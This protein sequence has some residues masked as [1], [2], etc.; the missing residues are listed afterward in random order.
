MLVQF[1]H[2]PRDAP[3]E[4]SLL[5]V[6]RNT[7]GREIGEAGER[8][9]RRV[10]RRP[11][12]RHAVSAQWNRG[13]RLQR[14]GQTCDSSSSGAWLSRSSSCRA[15]SRGPQHR[16]PTSIW[17]SATRRRMKRAQRGVGL[18]AGSTPNT[19]SKSATSSHRAAF[20][21]RTERRAHVEP[22]IAGHA[23]QGCLRWPAAPLRQ[24]PTASGLTLCTS[25]PV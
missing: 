10:R 17:L 19:S 11:I 14:Q 2:D 12:S 15:R 7:A 23:L 21:R 24:A 4:H 13:P 18:V 6:R 5:C 3:T 16:R 22:A 25:G 1:G 9:P 8:Q 20:R